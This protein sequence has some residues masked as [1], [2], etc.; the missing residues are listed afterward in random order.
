M[1][2]GEPFSTIRVG[3][4]CSPR[5]P[6]TVVP[7]GS[8]LSVEALVVKLRVAQSAEILALS[9]RLIALLGGPQG[10]ERR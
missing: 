6:G 8:G 1:A 10:C 4:T 2:H 3:A 7:G 9:P 5:F